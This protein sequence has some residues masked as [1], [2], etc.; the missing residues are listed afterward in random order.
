M[1]S[2]LFTESDV[3]PSLMT[4]LLPD[5]LGVPTVPIS[6]PCGAVESSLNGFTKERLRNSGDAGSG[7]RTDGGQVCKLIGV[8]LHPVCQEELCDP[9]RNVSI[10][11]N[12]NSILT[13]QRPVPDARLG[14]A[15]TGQ[16][17]H[18]PLL[19][20]STKDRQLKLKSVWWGVLRSV[21]G[22]S[23]AEI[24]CLGVSSI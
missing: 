22:R 17:Q 12:E 15:P 1:R 19:R 14:Y 13:P 6:S 24:E 10:N 3:E 4:D 2:S 5:G 7:P 11:P 16:K 9:G 20:F 8:L 18:N 21:G 23:G